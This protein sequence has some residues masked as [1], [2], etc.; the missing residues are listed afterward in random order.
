MASLDLAPS[1]DRS[2]APSP[3]ADVSAPRAPDAVGGVIDAA[4]GA[5]GAGDGFSDLMD[6]ALQARAQ[7]VAQG[8]GQDP[9]DV[10]RAVASIRDRL[11]SG[12]AVTRGDLRQIQDT[13]GQLSP[14]DATR[15]F[16]RLSDRTLGTLGEQL[17]DPTPF[18][19]GFSPADRSAF[20]GVLAERL[21][22]AQL[23]RVAG[24]VVTPREDGSG[25]EGQRLGAEIAGRAQSAV[26]VG[27]VREA[28]GQVGGDREAAFATGEV[29]AGLSGP[30][31][32]RALGTLRPDALR[33][34]VAGSVEETLTAQ[35]GYGSAHATLRYDADTAGRLLDTLATARDP[36]VRAVAVDAAAKALG[37][38]EQGLG[39]ASLGMTVDRGAAPARLRDG[40]TAILTADTGG[41]IGSLEQDVDRDGRALTTYVGSMIRAGRGAEVGALLVDLGTGGGTR[42]SA[43]WVTEQVAGDRDG[44]PYYE[45][46]QTLGYAVGT[47]HAAVGQITSDR[48]DRAEAV[49]A[50]FS[51]TLGAAGGLAGPAGGTAATVLSGLGTAGIDAVV[52]RYA[53]GDRELVSTLRELAFPRGAGLGPDGQ[54]AR[55]NGGA[56]EGYDSAVGRVLDAR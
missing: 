1:L 44:R 4:F 3:S 56:E 35:A 55:Y 14:S 42:P 47:V 45:N 15:T 34:V 32:D 18:V 43:A 22:G 10:D 6:R 37:E 11:D 33:A 20:Y 9:A 39:L 48:R 12:G 8:P 28:A 19:G 40:M 54:P 21:D 16:E 30:A 52:D 49:K 7:I 5:A 23:A 46:A 17:T 50:V 25:A 38:V 2:L 13:V 29:L 53:Q 36:Y 51:T 41:V 31:L 27:F 24:A 26:R